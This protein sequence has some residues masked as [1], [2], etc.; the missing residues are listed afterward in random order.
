MIINQTILI[1]EGTRLSLEISHWT[2]KSK[3]IR[4]S[5]SSNKI[6]AYLVCMTFSEKH[7]QHK[8]N[9]VPE[10]RVHFVLP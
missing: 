8:I 4:F 10:R 1:V 7:H 2:S 9:T 5:P 3:V 6:F